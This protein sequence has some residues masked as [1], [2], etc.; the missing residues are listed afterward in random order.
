V[1]GR[2]ADESANARSMHN[3]GRGIPITF[4]ACIRS[5]SSPMEPGLSIGASTASRIRSM[6]GATPLSSKNP[7]IAGKTQTPI[8]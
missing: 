7:G 6:F 2:L 8:L 5:R 4:E 1:A 3:G